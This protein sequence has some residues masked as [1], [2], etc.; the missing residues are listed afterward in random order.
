MPD[1]K[2]KGFKEMRKFIE[3]D[4]VE[5]VVED[6]ENDKEEEW[7]TWHLPSH[8]VLQK[9]KYRFCHDGRATVDGVCLNEQLIGDGNMIVMIA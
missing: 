8:L 7:P 2:E 6:R 1:K 4:K 5:K 9:G 3:N